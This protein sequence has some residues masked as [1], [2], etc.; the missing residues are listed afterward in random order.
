MLSAQ[1]LLA[2]PRVK[3]YK[4]IRMATILVIK[5]K[6][7]NV[8]PSVCAQLQVNGT[9]WINYLILVFNLDEGGVILAHCPFQ[10][11]CPYNTCRGC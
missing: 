8:M 10:Y 5:Q 3:R 7:K 11:H 1:R 6:T 4:I 9:L 2:L